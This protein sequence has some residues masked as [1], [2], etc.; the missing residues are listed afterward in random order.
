MFGSE[1]VQ[2]YVEVCIKSRIKFSSGSI[3]YLNLKLLNSP[4]DGL[5]PLNLT[6][7][8]FPRHRVLSHFPDFLY[9]F[10]AQGSS[11]II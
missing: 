2:S 5:Y 7:G 11:M 6:L 3:T 10:L 9:H 1:K 4:F 8:P